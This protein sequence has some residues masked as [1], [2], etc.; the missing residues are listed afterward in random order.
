M[1]RAA[2][3]VFGDAVRVMDVEAHL[4]QPSFT[5]RTLE[6]LV[7]AHPDRDFVLVVGSDILAETDRWKDFDRVKQ[8]AELL[9]LPRPG[10]TPVEA[11]PRVL[12]P[13]V[14]STAIRESLARGEDVRDWV[15]GTVLERIHQGRLYGTRS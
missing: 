4:P 8:L 12:F 15:P 5:V 3:A 6:H 7:Q 14:S 9:V 10:G 1:C 2:F 13:D 11:G